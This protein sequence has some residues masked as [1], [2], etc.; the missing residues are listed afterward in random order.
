MPT[1]EIS[2]GTSSPRLRLEHRAGGTLEQHLCSSVLRF[3]YGKSPRQSFCCGPKSDS[4]DN[5][6]AGVDR[7]GLTADGELI[8]FPIGTEFSFPEICLIKLKR[9]H[10]DPAL[11]KFTKAKELAISEIGRF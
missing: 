8:F 2:F 10:E 9:A 3:I 6:G 1:T 5:R 4:F 7:K 11:Q